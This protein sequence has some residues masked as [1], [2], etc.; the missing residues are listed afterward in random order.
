MTFFTR[1]TLAALAWFNAP[2]KLQ[3]T[4]SPT[5]AEVDGDGLQ[6]GMSIEESMKYLK[7]PPS[8]LTRMGKDVECWKWNG[9]VAREDSWLIFKNGK[10]SE[11]T[12]AKVIAT[13]VA[14]PVWK[15][16]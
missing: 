3:N 6:I 9:L 14:M 11:Y 16:N 10:L 13:K 15:E 7:S 5:L 12:N 2:L 4:P 1:W 8:T